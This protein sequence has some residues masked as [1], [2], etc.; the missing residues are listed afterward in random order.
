MSK[1]YDHTSIK[2]LK[3][4]EHIRS[5]AGMYIGVRDNPNH[6]LYELFDNSLDEAQGGFASIIGV[7][8]NTEDNIISIADN[9]R[10]IPFKNETI[11]LLATKLFTGGK[12]DKGENEVYKI[13]TGLH[14]IGIVAVNALSDF[15]EIIVYRDN[16]KVYYRFENA[17]IVDSKIEKFDSK[18]R[19]FSTQIKFKPSKKYFESL[20]FDINKIR[21]RLKIS[22]IHIDS[23]KLALIID[24]NKEIINC[25]LT[26][27]FKD[28]LSI[29]NEITKT[30]VLENKNKDEYVKI[31]L[32][33]ELGSTVG[34]KSIGCVNLLQV[35]KGT[36]INKTLDI[37]KNVFEKIATKDKILK[38]NRDDSLLCLRCYTS[39]LL[40][41]P[42]YSSQTKE[43]L[44]IS[45]KKLDKLYSN[46]ESLLENK[47]LKDEDLKNKLFSFW[48][49]YRKKKDSSKAITKA[50]SAKIGSTSRLNN[51]LDSKLRDC[52]T[53]SIRNSELFIVEG[54]SACGSLIQAR[55]PKYH[56][57]LGLKGKIRN[58]ASDKKDHLKNKEIVEIINALGTGL[59]PDFD[60]SGLRYGKIITSCDADPDGSH[61]SV[62]LL[63]LFLKLVPD[64]IKK[65][66]I[67][68]AIMPLYGTTINKKFIPIYSKT[69]LDEIKNKYNKCYIQRYKGLGEMNPDQLEVCLFSN[70]RK[71]QKIE[72][73][74]K[75]EEVFELMLNANRKRD[76][77]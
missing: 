77:V 73:P 27:Y 46:L 35:D 44:S 42:E 7:Q 40:Y 54:D 21:Q 64:L 11:P 33:W 20:T 75:P 45:K 18:K 63:V 2:A 22:S 70:K 1:K 37:V 17:V 48:D 60:I 68:R 67:Y 47:L 51:S 43:K 66:K 62:L 34:C 30:I 39:V 29:K 41:D 16:K 9:G 58:I 69:E 56:A 25:N 72:H 12:F 49:I 8:I 14:G 76:L 19:P 32:C 36:H 4:I 65:G 53:H 50:V 15:L 57:I 6:L 52:T 24:D 31:L 59:E 28:S 5:K 3:D 74:D 38:Y 71:L 61:I 55:N 13:S 26:D 23:L 10:G